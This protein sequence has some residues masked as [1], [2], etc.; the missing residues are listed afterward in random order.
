MNEV[1]S[2]V[3]PKDHITYGVDCSALLLTARRVLERS[4]G[5]IEP[6][7]RRLEALMETLSLSFTPR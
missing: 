6:P 1:Q 2:T 5:E 4:R 7:T 3:W